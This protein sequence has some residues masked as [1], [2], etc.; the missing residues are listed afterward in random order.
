MGCRPTPL[1]GCV[2]AGRAKLTISE[3]TAGQERLKTSLQELNAALGLIDFG[4]PVSGPTRYDVCIHNQAGAL[5]GQMTVNR[6]QQTCGTRPCWKATGSV[7]YR[8]SDA[9]A[10]A[11]GIRSIGTKSG[12]IGTGN[13]KVKGGNMVSVGQTSLPTGMTAALSGNTQAVVQ[14]I[15]SDARCY[16]ATLTTV[17]KNTPQQFTGKTP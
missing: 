1:A 13:V 12:S 15:T 14:V 17:T 7:G 4:N 16:Q 6:A 3:K 10:S 9:T 5:V 8:Y 11:S 2:V